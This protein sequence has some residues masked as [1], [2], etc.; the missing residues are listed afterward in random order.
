MRSNP[1]TAARYIKRRAI[2]ARITDRRAHYT[3]KETRAAQSAVDEVLSGNG[4]LIGAGNF[5]VAYEVEVGD[6]KRLVKMGSFDTIHSRSHARHA[7]EIEDVSM[8]RRTEEAARKSQRTK[9]QMRASLLH[10]AG[11]ANELWALGFRC[12]PNTIFVERGLPAIVREFGDVD[13]IVSRSQLD[14]LSLDLVAVLNAGWRVQDELLIAKRLYV[15]EDAPKNSLFIADVGIWQWS[16]KAPEVGDLMS[17]FGLIQRT[18]KFPSLAELQFYQ[19][20]LAEMKELIAI[21][22]ELQPVADDVMDDIAR[23]KA[24]RAK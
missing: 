11:V 15:E 12:V 3:A 17:L 4:K 18:F 9:A 5:G 13:A 24:Q 20:Y 21:D 6:K 10:E 19:G 16:G 8:R 22:P 7:R 2:P 1:V 14:Q 23:I